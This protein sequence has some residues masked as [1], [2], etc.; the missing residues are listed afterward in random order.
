MLGGSAAVRTNTTA[1][2]IEINLNDVISTVRI[3]KSVDSW[4]NTS[5][6]FGIG[7]SSPTEKLDVNGRAFMS[8]QS[9]PATPTGGGTLFVELGALRYIGSSGTVTTL[10]VA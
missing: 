6:N 9:Q 10:G 4:I 1:N 2:S 7:T 8:N 5:A 3:G